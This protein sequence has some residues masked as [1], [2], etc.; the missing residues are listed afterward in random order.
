MIDKLLENKLVNTFLN[1][2]YGMCIGIIILMTWVVIVGFLAIIA[3]T[4]YSLL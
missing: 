1:I 4:V 2:T 3:I